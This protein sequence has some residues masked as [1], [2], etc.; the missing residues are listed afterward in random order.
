M[1]VF[2]LCLEY[3]SPYRSERKH[4]T[5]ACTCTSQSDVSTTFGTR[6]SL[7]SVLTVLTHT[8]ARPPLAVAK[9]V[10]ASNTNLAGE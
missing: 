4:D 8:N 1:H 3:E 7:T 10:L 6:R 2:Q 5:S 9:V